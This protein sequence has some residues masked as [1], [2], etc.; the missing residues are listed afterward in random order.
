[1]EQPDSTTTL[2]GKQYGYK[3]IEQVCSA[4]FATAFALRD[5]RDTI[6]KLNKCREDER[7]I[8]DDARVFRSYTQSG[9]LHWMPDLEIA[10]HRV[11]DARS[12][13]GRLRPALYVAEHG[14]LFLPLCHIQ[15]ST[16]TI[17][18]R[19]LDDLNDIVEPL[20]ASIP[21]EWKPENH[22]A[23]DALEPRARRAKMLPVYLAAVSSRHD[24]IIT[25]DV[26]M[27][28]DQMWDRAKT[29]NRLMETLGQAHQPLL[30]GSLLIAELGYLACASV[31]YGGQIDDAYPVADRFP[32]DFNEADDWR[33]Y[34]S[35]L[36]RLRTI[37][38][39]T[40]LPAACS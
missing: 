5:V 14:S 24:S 33:R 8:K 1:M 35:L 31:N 19:V 36:Q 29:A 3:Q 13:V 34:A 37:S 17:F 20:T 12:V 2:F 26:Q 25:T 22:E 6:Q 23:W 39:L 16:K 30:D 10:G 21:A 7:N 32:C 9:S 27:R 15:S 18:D 40:P 38:P 4:F 28:V 11:A